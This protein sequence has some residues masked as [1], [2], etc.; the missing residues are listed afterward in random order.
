M[1]CRKR[2]EV[3]ASEEQSGRSKGAVPIN[4]LQGPL[5]L[6]SVAGS[7]RD[8]LTSRLLQELPTKFGTAIRYLQAWNAPAQ[9]HRSPPVPVA[10][11]HNLSHAHKAKQAACQTTDGLG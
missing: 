5:V 1:L 8:A 7:S 9:C 10:G 6:C 2:P 11:R 3:L 4:P